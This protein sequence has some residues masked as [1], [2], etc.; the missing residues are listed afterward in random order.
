[1]HQSYEFEDSHYLRSGKGYKVDCG[2]CFEH[3]CSSSSGAKPISPIT[4]REESGLIPPTL[5]RILVNPTSSSHTPPR[6][7]GIPLAH[8]PQ[9]PRRNKMADDMKL[10]VFRG[11]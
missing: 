9:P 6:G 4:N 3:R 1:M 7:Q 2:D 8:N 5:Q 10:L 11:T